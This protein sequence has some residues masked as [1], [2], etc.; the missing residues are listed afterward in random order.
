M[1]SALAT[2][3]KLQPLSGRRILAPASTPVNSLGKDTLKLS[4]TATNRSISAS[5]ARNADL[6]TAIPPLGRLDYYEQRMADFKRRHPDLP[7]PTYYKDFADKYVKK[8][9]YEV[10]PQLT[11]EGREWQANSRKA[12]QEAMEAKRQADPAAFD[13]LERDDKAFMAFAYGTHA[14]AY[15]KPGLDKLLVSDLVKIGLGPDL[16]DLISPEGRDQIYHIG[17]GIAEGK[18]R[19]LMDC[20]SR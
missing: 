18:V 11:P 2:S 10:G 8:L 14:D 3:F 17:L 19:R 1:L 12:L 6:P 4:P 13:R 20:E 9:T 7:V 15:L 16:I 5:P